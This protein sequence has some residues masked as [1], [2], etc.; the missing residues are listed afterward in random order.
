VGVRG[1]DTHAAESEGD[2]GPLAVGALADGG[3]SRVLS[4]IGARLA[5]SFAK[6]SMLACWTYARFLA[7]SK[8]ELDTFWKALIEDCRTLISEEAARRSHG[9]GRPLD[10][11]AF[12]C[13][14]TTFMATRDRLAA[15]Q[16]GDGFVVV[17]RAA[18]SAPS[19]DGD[20]RFELLFH[21][22]EAEEAS[23]V[24]WITATNWL[25]D[26]QHAVVQ[27]GPF[28]ML[29][30]SS[31]GIANIVLAPTAGDA[32]QLHPHQPFFAKLRK[33]LRQELM[34]CQTVSSEALNNRVADILSDPELDNWVDDDKSVVVAL[35]TGRADAASS[36]LK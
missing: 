11:G 3:G 4:H 19:A 21:G 6:S 16:V 18:E 22:R 7:A 33:H 27:D 5:A 35:W 28:D 10:P 24:V 14:L 15:A 31:D 17:G 8:A 12:A 1:S 32:N 9:A 13:T 36:P 20:A 25:A 30:A 29:M 2:C 26:Y 34:R 23:Q